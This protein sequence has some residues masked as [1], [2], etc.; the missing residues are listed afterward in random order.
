MHY[1]TAEGATSSLFVITTT[2]SRQTCRET[3]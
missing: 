3:L 2:K 1:A